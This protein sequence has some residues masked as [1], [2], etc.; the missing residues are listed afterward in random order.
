[1]LLWLLDL[2]QKEEIFSSKS[3]PY[4]PDFGGIMQSVELE[5]KN[6]MRNHPAANGNAFTIDNVF[7]ESFL[8]FL[9][10]I[11]SI[12]KIV[13]G[14]N[15]PDLAGGGEKSEND[16]YDQNRGGS[17]DTEDATSFC[18]ER[19]YF[20]DAEGVIGRELARAILAQSKGSYS[21][22]YS[23]R[24]VK[25]VTVFPDMRFL[26][27]RQKGGGLPPHTDLSR[28]IPRNQLSTSTVSSSS[29]ELP[30]SSALPASSELPSSQN[31][32]QKKK[33]ETTSSST[34]SSSTLTSTHTFILY[35]NEVGEGGKHLE[36]SRSMKT[37]ERADCLRRLRFLKWVRTLLKI[38]ELFLRKKEISMRLT[39]RRDLRSEVEGSSDRLKKQEQKQEKKEAQSSE[40]EVNPSSLFPFSIRPSVSSASLS[41]FLQDHWEVWK[42][43][44]NT[45]S[46]PLEKVKGEEQEEKEEEK[47]EED[48]EEELTHVLN[49]EFSRCAFEA[50]VLG[51]GIL[52]KPKKKKKLKKKKNEFFLEEALEDIF[53]TNY[54]I[55]CCDLEFSSN[56]NSCSSSSSCS[57]ERN[58]KQLSIPITRSDH[59]QSESDE[60][61]DPFI[62]SNPDTLDALLLNALAPQSLIEYCECTKLFFADTARALAILGGT[63]LGDRLKQEE[64]NF[65]EH[66]ADVELDVRKLKADLNPGKEDIFFEDYLKEDSHCEEDSNLEE[67]V[68][69]F[70]E[71]E[72]E[73]DEKEVVQSEQRV[74]FFQKEEVS[75]F[76][77]LLQSEER[78]ED[79]GQLLLN[80]KEGKGGKFGGIEETK[81]GGETTLLDG[82]PGP[83]NNH[84]TRRLA[85]IAPKSGR[86]FVF[87]HA[88][89]HQAEPVL[90]PPKLLLRGEMKIEWEGQG[91]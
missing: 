28:T 72:G 26:C 4:S 66:F 57:P 40:G 55:P 85:S 33:E 15:N 64:K 63:I 43:K 1:M 25:N 17:D 41:S 44:A 53:S 61:S 16:N 90:I 62:L 73:E 3:C 68:F 18:S 47:E 51:R 71:E 70:Q 14:K 27:Y 80:S 82:L 30:S 31:Q 54:S 76:Q 89:P 83:K 67:E 2:E 78:A 13:G 45:F 12:Q 24:E 84:K 87:P 79:N 81:Q 56:T 75:F 52:K 20:C 21:G 65:G 36:S 19:R 5:L 34:S 46:S 39:A 9:K 58:P 49:R 60:E 8:D 91:E 6:D 38:R 7:F 86:L 42:K 74:S 69:F 23:E 48:E 77:E 32:S 88:A 11:F 10:D 35:L 29:S 37:R 59:N 50:R 22:S